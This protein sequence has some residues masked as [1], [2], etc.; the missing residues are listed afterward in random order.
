MV[1][2]SAETTESTNKSAGL[3]ELSELSEL[4]GL[5]EL[6]A[7]QLG[8]SGQG[9]PK[10]TKPNSAPRGIT[11]PGGAVFRSPP[12]PQGAALFSPNGGMH[13]GARPDNPKHS[14]N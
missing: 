2:E 13:G 12:P 11:S 9:P 4:S 7:P 14:F 8:Q 10:T 3:S 6:S 1:T 5:S